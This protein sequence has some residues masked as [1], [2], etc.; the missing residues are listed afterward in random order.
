MVAA[1]ISPSHTFFLSCGHKIRRRQRILGFRVSPTKASINS[2]HR[3][4]RK[5]PACGAAKSG[6]TGS[7]ENGPSS[8]AIGAAAPSDAPLRRRY[9]ATKQY[10]PIGAGSG[11]TALH[12]VVSLG[13][14]VDR[15]LEREAVDDT[16]QGRDGR[17]PQD[18]ARGK[19][20]MRVFDDARTFL[21]TSYR[22]LLHPPAD[23]FRIFCEQART[24]LFGGRPPSDELLRGWD[25]YLVSLESFPCLVS[26]HAVDSYKCG[27]EGHVSRDCTM[28]G[29]RT[30]AVWMVTSCVPLLPHLYIFCRRRRLTKR[31]CAGTVIDLRLSHQVTHSLLRSPA[32]APTTNQ[33]PEVNSPEEDVV[34]APSTIAAA[35]RLHRACLDAVPA[36]EE[37]AMA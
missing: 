2:S 19:D 27:L 34:A 33:A 28:E 3:A 5:S 15:L 36:E 35:R 9:S 23:A 11:N 17:T 10:R 8:L 26:A 21:T 32:T 29:K 16:L 13:P 24:Y 7:S 30:M 22:S 1:V 6:P 14:V 12:L 31:P 4:R 25:A 37:E 18:V 20:V